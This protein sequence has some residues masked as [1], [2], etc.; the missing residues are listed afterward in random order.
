MLSN[1][2]LGTKFKVVHG[3]PGAAEVDLAVENG[4]VQGEAGKDWTTLTST[5]VGG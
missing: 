1:R 5:P 3:Y 2:L 4:E